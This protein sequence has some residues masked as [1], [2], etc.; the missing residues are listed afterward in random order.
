MELLM[1]GHLLGDFYFQTNKLAEKKRTSIVYTALHC[2]IY[3]LVMFAVLVITTGNLVECV[4]PTLLIGAL[5]LL[6]DEIKC[7]VQKCVKS[8]KHE[9]PI[10]VVDQIIHLGILFIISLLYTINYDIALI[11]SVSEEFL[12]SMQ[13]ILSPVHLNP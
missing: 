1:M 4:R 9:L 6:V 5:H 11:P 3:S 8:I 7:I 10:F 2:F 12:S 13:T